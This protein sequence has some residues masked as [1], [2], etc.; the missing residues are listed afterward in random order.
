M[1]FLI[2]NLKHSKYDILVLVWHKWIESP[3]DSLDSL[4]VRFPKSCLGR[5]PFH[6]YGSL[7]C[8]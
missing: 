7:S 6:K 4:V 3:I 2:K 8:S 5:S 1:K